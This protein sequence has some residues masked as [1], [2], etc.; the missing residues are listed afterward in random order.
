MPNTQRFTAN[1]VL[2]DIEGTISPVAFVR[3][4][5]FAYSRDHLVAF[6]AEH[7]GTPAVAAILSEAAALANGGDPVAALMGWQDRDEKIPPLKKLQ[8]LIWESGYR[9]G[10]YR[11]Y[12]F[13]DALAALTRWKAA[14]LPLYIYSSGSVQAQNLFFGY[15]EAG[16]IRPLFSGYYD[17]EVG[18]K[19][20]P[21]AYSRIAG[22]IGMLP[23][24]ILFLSD[25]PRE[26]EAA[27]S[28]GLQ[29]AQVIKDGTR[30]DDRYPGI[31]NFSGVDIAALP[32][33]PD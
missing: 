16:D 12:L 30:R 3:D 15:N 2:L 11:G 18:A 10:A 26:L 8:G 24:H 23:H 29:V 21:A 1:A 6:A 19:T 28:A 13:P 31:T 17:T 25:N 5:L 14:G 22:E 7:R 32:I 27:H 20:D 33:D 9:S 4:V